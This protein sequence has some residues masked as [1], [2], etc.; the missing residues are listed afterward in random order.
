MSCEG[1]GAVDQLAET[2]VAPDLGNLTVELPFEAAERVIDHLPPTPGPSDAKG[3][4]MLRIPQRAWKL[5]NDPTSAWQVVGS[6]QSATPLP[7]QR[8][9]AP[10]PKPEGCVRFVAISDTHSCEARRPDKPLHVPDGDVLLHAGDWTQVGDLREVEAF[11]AWFGELPHARKILI[12]GNHD[13]SMDAA[14]YDR[15]SKVWAKM[16]G[17]GESAA[18]VCARARAMVDA[19]PRCE[20]LCDSGTSVRG[21]SVWGSPWQPEFCNWA[22][23]LPRGEPCREKWALIPSGTDVVMTH[24]PPL[25][26][27]DLCSSGLR[28]GCLDLLSELQ[29]RV[30]PKYHVFGHIHEGHGATT[31]GVTTYLNASSCTLQY[32]PD[33]A[34]LVF[35]LPSRD[36]SEARG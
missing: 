18:D 35:D 2:A 28:A 19:I 27:G 25:G 22:F 31:D 29:A 4:D 36:S 3:S 23:N 34:P 24:G 26:H 10:E 12:A 20:Y 9:T 6:A 13:L 7:I 15:T 14:S 11:C 30:R 5:V 16:R 8:F 32:R 21:I 33:N 1:S 17:R